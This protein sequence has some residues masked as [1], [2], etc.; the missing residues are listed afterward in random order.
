[1]MKAAEVKKSMVEPTDQVWT[2]ASEAERSL[3]VVGL[4]RELRMVNDKVSI[5]LKMKMLKEKEG[6]RK[7]AENR[8]LAYERDAGHCVP[9]YLA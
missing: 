1:M 8:R 2:A 5:S 4:E 6:K 3:F 9:D 7:V